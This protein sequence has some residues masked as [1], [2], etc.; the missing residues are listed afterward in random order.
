MASDLSKLIQDSITL[1]LNGLLA[2]DAKILQI[3]QTHIKD[4]EELQVLKVQ[5][6]FDFAS[7]SSEFS[8]FVPAKSS[9][10]IFN[11]MMGSPITELADEIDDDSEDAIGEFISNTSGTLT[12]SINGAKLEDIGQTKFNIS[13]KEIIQG[14][15]LSSLENTYRFLIDLEGNELIIFIAFDAAIIPYIQEISVSE[16]TYHE[17]VIQKQ[18]I[19]EENKIKDVEKDESSVATEKPEEKDV[20]KDESSVKKDKKLKLIIFIVGGLLGFII[21]TFFIMYF[22]GV[23]EPEPLIEK[24][25]DANTTQ[26]IKA[27]NEVEIVKYTTLKKVIFKTS[28][29]DKERLNSKLA[30]LTK[31]KVLNKEELE[32]QKLAEK[33][34]LFELEK[35]KELLAFSKKNQE[36]PLFEKKE[37]EQTRIVDKKTKFK[38]ETFTILKDDVI[39]ADNI[40]VIAKE[41]DKPIIINKPVIIDKVE[42]LNYIVTNSLKYSLFKELVQK[43][44]TNQARISICNNSKGKTT[45]YI[46]PFETEIL[47]QEMIKLIENK[48][49]QID[50]TPVNITEE[51]FNTR[52]NLE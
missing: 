7:F 27:K 45:I 46:G 26:I 33:S 47:Q 50:I 21:I 38:K 4:I 19:E 13:H 29:I 25:E 43:T 36:E 49:L 20:E 42:T 39:I 32:A 35:E 12:T 51:E 9:S 52:C 37:L 34:R 40:P 16:I 48:N 2:K 23:F 6:V 11:T 15:D 31:Y 8:F 3:T 22:I 14:K 28:D 18:S 44:N 41:R 10:L 30:E 17:E 5:S 24:K 1:T